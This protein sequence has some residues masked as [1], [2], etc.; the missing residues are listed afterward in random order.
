MLNKLMNHLI[1]N[2]KKAIKEDKIPSKAEGKGKTS[3]LD[4]A[5]KVCNKLFE[6]R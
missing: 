5:E 2:A 4:Y 1:K 3:S 6:H